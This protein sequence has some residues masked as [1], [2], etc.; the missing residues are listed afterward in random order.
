M[1]NVIMNEI[2][3]DAIVVAADTT[4]GK[5]DFGVTPFDNLYPLVGIHES[6]LNGILTL[7][8]FRDTPHQIR[9]ALLFLSFIIVCFAFYRKN[10]IAFH[11]IYAAALC[12]HIALV[13]FLWFIH[14]MVPWFAVPFFAILF[15]WFMVFALR[16]LKAREKRLLL[17]EAMGRYFPRSLAEKILAENKT[18]LVPANKEVTILFADIKGFTNWS[19]EK[20]AETVHAFLSDYL[21]S[22]AAIIFENGGTVD[23]FL[24]DGILAFFGDPFEQPD[25]TER[26][27]RAAIAMQQK[28]RILA[29]KWE[30]LVDID[31]KIRVGINT[32]RVIVGN[33]GTKTRIEY[34]V[35]GAAVNLAQRMESNAPAGGVL[36]TAAV[37]EKVKDNFNFL[38]RMDVEVKGYDEPIESYV[39]D[40]TNYRW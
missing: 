22:M 9:F 40:I 17:T 28:A 23:K 13:C 16:L 11:F 4:S 35:I 6:I 3:S 25:H 36:V 32:G 15:S 10:D 39:V 19:S 29:V 12:L 14:R 5:K 37:R 27:V 34:T 2:G 21:E 20:E 24:G 31:L 7:Q 33:L 30:P 1:W 18:D 38:E 26:C 8:F